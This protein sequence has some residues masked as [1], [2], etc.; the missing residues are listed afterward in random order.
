M[1]TPAI[2]LLGRKDEPTD[3][4]EQYCRFLG[5]ALRAHDI[6]LD[7][8]RVPWEHHGWTDSLHALHL[9]ASQWRGHWVLVQ[10]TALAWSKRG[11]PQ[12]ILRVLRILQRAGARIGIVFH[13][14]EPFYADKFSAAV[15]RF[16]QVRVMR[17]LVRFSE[18]S[19]FT[20]PVERISW[21]APNTPRVLFIPDGPN[22]PIHEGVASSVSHVPPTVAVFS[23]TGGPSGERETQTI[24]AALRFASERLGP[25]RLLVFGRQSEVRESALRSG[26]RDV[27]VQ[28]SVEGVLPD[29]QLVQRFCDSDVL[30]FVR[31]GISS[32]RGSAIAGIACGLPV[33]ASAGS[34]TAPP[35][36]DAGVVFVSLK[37]PDEINAA[38]VRVL[39][40]SA[41]RLELAARSQAVFRDHL[42]WPVIARQF[43]GKLRP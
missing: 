28:V 20:V 7:I 33:I 2:A 26:L 15:R 10:Y 34:E 1:T 31:G 27:P 29:E 16:L 18:F 32:R 19:I 36:T 8:R 4:V 35:I 40:D 39:S 14:V 37:N 41:Y 38:L 23:I 3:A 22:L 21:L 30:L 43:A 42:A 12:R 9:M 17:K 6:Q 25:L 13:D 5:A 11:F 24:T